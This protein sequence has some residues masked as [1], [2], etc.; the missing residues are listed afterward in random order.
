LTLWWH[1]VKLLLTQSAV[2]WPSVREL[3]I[4]LRTGKGSFPSASLI[5]QLPTSTAFPQLRYL[6]F[7][8]RRF[9]L[10]PAE[11]LAKRIISWLDGLVSAS[12]SFTILHLNRCCPFYRS[13]HRDV[14]R[15]KLLALLDKHM[16]SNYQR[17]SPTKIIIDSNEEIIIW[18]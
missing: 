17:R 5:A 1:D 10:H 15:D 14:A 8:S 16:S 9:G 3:N 13:I 2:P 4:R 6:S 11:V 12:P 7:R 18:L